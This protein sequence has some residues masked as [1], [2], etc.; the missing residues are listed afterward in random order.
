VVVCVSQVA[1][2][3]ISDKRQD[4][5]ANAQHTKLACCQIAF[6]APW[7]APEEP[8]KHNLGHVYE[9]AQHSSRQH[10]LLISHAP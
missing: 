7:P 6:K 8:G 3:G 5:D 1:R 9:V 10:A 4:Y 2:F